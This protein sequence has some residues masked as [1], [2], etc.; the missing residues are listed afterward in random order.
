MWSSHLRSSGTS[1]EVETDDV[2]IKYP[3]DAADIE[4]HTAKEEA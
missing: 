2:W 4:E 1:T 3:W